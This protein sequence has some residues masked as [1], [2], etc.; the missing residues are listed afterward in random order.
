MAREPPMEVLLHMAEQRPTVE[1]QPTAATM[2]TVLPT[3]V[4]TQEAVH[5]VG[6]A[7]L[8]TQLPSQT[9]LPRR[10]ALTTLPRQVHMPRRRLVATEHTLHLRPAAQ[11]THRHPAISLRPHRAIVGMELRLL[12]RPRRVHGTLRPRRRAA[13]IPATIRWVRLYNKRLLLS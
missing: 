13:R 5:P 2:A 4:S 3:A 9:S 6:E 7:H 12:P 8:A 1:E 11:W 10:Q